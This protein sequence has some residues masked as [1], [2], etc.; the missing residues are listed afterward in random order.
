MS[1]IADR[2]RELKETL[3][4]P[5]VEID[6][7]QVKLARKSFTKEDFRERAWRDHAFFCQ[8]LFPLAFYVPFCTAHMEIIELMFDPHPCVS[9]IAPRKLGKTPII[10]F[11]YPMKCAL[12]DMESYIVIV[13]ETLDESKRHV[14][15]ITAALETNEKLHYYYGSFIDRKNRETQ[16][17]SVQLTTGLWI[18]AKSYLKQI[19][20]TAGDW[21]PPSLIIVDDPQSNKD[22]KTEKAL[23]DAKNWFNDEIMYSKAQRWRHARID[24]VGRGKVRFL[25]TSLHPLCLAE[26]MDADTRF[27]SKRYSILQNEHGEPDTVNGT[28][29]WEAMFPTAELIAEMNEAEKNQTLGNWL[30]ERMNMPYKFGDRKFDVEDMRYWDIGGNHFD[31]VNGIPCL[32]QETL[33]KLEEELVYGA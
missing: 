4:P 20:G 11:S 33:L 9:V 32:V 15:K 26:I 17:D 13:S 12:Y 18:R 19:R 5:A 25:G 21:T 30:Q 10:C 1:S 7:P 31:I 14:Q 3:K 2:V 24:H 29:I 16:K 6:S 28:S 27:L 8:E 23:T 22:V